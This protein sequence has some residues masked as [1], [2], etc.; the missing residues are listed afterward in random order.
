MGKKKR[1]NKNSHHN[2]QNSNNSLEDE[3]IENKD[4]DEDDQKNEEHDCSEVIDEQDDTSENEE[5][6]ETTKKNDSSKIKKESK[7]SS[8]EAKTKEE[9]IK[10]LG[11]DFE[12]ICNVVNSTTAQT[13]TQDTTPQSCLTNLE[14]LQQVGSFLQ[15]IN[16]I[17]I[18]LAR[19]DTN[20]A[21]LV[22]YENE[23]FPILNTLFFLAGIIGDLSLTARN[24]QQINSVKTSK[25]QELI[26]LNYEVDKLIERVFRLVEVKVYKLIRILGN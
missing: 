9:I 2:K 6:Q 24:L 10:L 22:Y 18:E 23:L 26:E 13:I 3:N 11:K 7:K 16:G 15:T 5:N 1:H 4:E 25:L 14:A 21:G 20:L 17:R 12:K 19:L 8:E